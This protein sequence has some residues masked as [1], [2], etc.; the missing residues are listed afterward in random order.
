[1]ENGRQ[2]K[3]TYRKMGELGNRFGELAEHLVLPSIM[4]KFNDLGF[5]FIK[6][7][8]SCRVRE[9][10]NPQIRAEIDIMLENQEMVVAVE[11]K[12]RPTQGD[13]N[14]HIKR[15]KILRQ[16]ADSS[17]DN[18]KYCGAIAGAIMVDAVRNY[19]I[20]KGFYVIEQSGDTVRINIPEGFAPREW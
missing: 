15:M 18:R 3:E 19:I 8:S 5:L 16:A 1:M 14:D 4:D 6:T 20:K 12:S 9:K 7:S 2:M 13:V 11:V 10:D 17:S